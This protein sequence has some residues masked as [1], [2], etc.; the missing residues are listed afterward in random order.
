MAA[1][2]ADTREAVF[3]HVGRWG[4]ASFLIAKYVLKLPIELS[5]RETKSKRASWLE[6]INMSVLEEEIVRKRTKKN[7]ILCKQ[8]DTRG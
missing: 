5:E 6:L 7:S 3:F 2:E 1:A 4:Y 8:R